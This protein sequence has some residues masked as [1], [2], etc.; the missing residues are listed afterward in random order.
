MSYRFIDHTA[1][2]MIEVKGDNLEE[3]LNSVICAI[4]EYCW[5]LP[6]N[7]GKASETLKL[8]LSADSL[9]ELVYNFLS[10]LIAISDAK[11]IVPLRLRALEVIYDTTT[12]NSWNLRTDLLVTNLRELRLQPAGHIK[13]VTYHEFTFRYNLSSGKTY[14]KVLFDI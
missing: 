10:E 5:D 4:N 6:L 3:A 2:L 13:A 14:L 9:D 8:K 1:D 12:T 7:E 11:K